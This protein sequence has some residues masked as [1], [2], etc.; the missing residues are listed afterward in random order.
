MFLSAGLGQNVAR[1]IALKSGLPESI[2]ATSIDDVCGSS[3]KV[4]L[5][6]ATS[7]NVTW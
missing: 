3:L 7:A 4:F 2:V 6:F 1:Q 5:R